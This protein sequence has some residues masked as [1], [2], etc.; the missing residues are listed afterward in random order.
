MFAKDTILLVV[1][2]RDYNGNKVTPNDVKL[3]I[4]DKQETPIEEIT[5]GL[6]TDGLGKFEYEYTDTTGSDFIFEFS[7][8][9]N[10]K[11]ILARQEVN[12]KFN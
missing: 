9:F 2:F 11:P 10:E 12:V 1:Q 7:G 4:Y 8:V 6:A 5:F 3:T